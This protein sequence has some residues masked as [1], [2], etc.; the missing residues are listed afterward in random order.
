[1]RKGRIKALSTKSST[2]KTNSSS[3]SNKTSTSTNSTSAQVTGYENV[4]KYAGNLQ[5][6]AKSLA[7]LV[8]ATTDTVT[9]ESE[10]T[11]AVK[12]FISDYNNLYESLD[13]AGGTTNTVFQKQ[14]KACYTDAK[15]ELSAAGI[16]MNTKGM[17]VLDTTKLEAADT[18]TLQQIFKGTDSYANKVSSK[19][20]SI[21]SCAASTIKVLNRMYGT[22]TSYNR[23]GSS[24]Y[25]YGSSGSRYSAGS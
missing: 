16:T 6:D 12:E 14:L 20:Q 25:Y 24:S 15:S 19:C 22:Q 7:T 8:T 2:N 5:K 4:E 3:S 11:S 21:E 10:L 18:E 17:L 9:Q 23:Y 1:M 13:D